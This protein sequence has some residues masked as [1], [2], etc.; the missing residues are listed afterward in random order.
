MN[1]ALLDAHRAARDTDTRWALISQVVEA[2]LITRC[3][4]E[5]WLTRCG[6]VC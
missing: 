5:G 6:S 3:V 4:A 1:G 2:A